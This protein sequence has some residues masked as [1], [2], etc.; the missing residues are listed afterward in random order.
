MGM[1]YMRKTLYVC[2]QN[3]RKV[4]DRESEEMTTEAKWKMENFS[5]FMR[6][7]TYL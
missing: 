4:G 5:K 7:V 2:N 6:I 3:P 1:W